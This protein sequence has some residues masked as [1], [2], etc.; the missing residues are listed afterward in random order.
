MPS[1]D[2]ATYLP[3]HLSFYGPIRLAAYL[4]PHLPSSLCLSLSLSI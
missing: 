3:I 4:P 1:M 2:L